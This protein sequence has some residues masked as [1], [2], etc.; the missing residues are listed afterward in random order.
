MLNLIGFD[1]T[2]CCL[3]KTHVVREA[4]G[5]QPAKNEALRLTSY[6]ELNFAK[7]DVSSE[8]DFSPLEPSDV[9]LPLA[10]TA[11]PVNAAL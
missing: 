2:N 1:E 9:T 8:T 11:R 3:R 10:N 5:Q 4:S 7:N 6:K